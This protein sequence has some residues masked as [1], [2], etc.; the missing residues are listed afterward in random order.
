MPKGR[1]R[2]PKKIQREC[3]FNERLMLEVELRLPRAFDGK[4]R[5]GVFTALVESLL[6]RWLN[7]QALATNPQGSTQ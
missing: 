7:E 4:V 5:T 3:Q 2:G 1:P 6:Q